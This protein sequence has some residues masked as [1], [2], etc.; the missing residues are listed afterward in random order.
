MIKLNSTKMNFYA[1]QSFRLPGK[2]P[3]LSCESD[4]LET[5]NEEINHIK[6][7]QLML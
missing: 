2:N 6:E 3:L 7:L 5:E 1:T 4:S